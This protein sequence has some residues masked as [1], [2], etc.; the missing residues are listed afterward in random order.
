[1][2]GIHALPSPLQKRN[3]VNK[4]GQREKEREE[5]RDGRENESDKAEEKAS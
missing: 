3:G 5:D 4:K 2:C 1:M